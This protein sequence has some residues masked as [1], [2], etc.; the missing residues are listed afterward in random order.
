MPY[1]TPLTDAEA[2]DALRRL[3]EWT[4]DGDWIARTVELPTFRDAI[5]L[6]T[7][8]ADAAEQANHHPNI[9]IRWRR[10]S[11]RLTTHSAKALT[12]RDVDLAAR[13]DELAARGLGIE[14]P[15]R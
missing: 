12:R 4:R 9:D 13:I 5:A 14:S 2:D 3:P 8:V 7:A 6:V 11:F 15:R 10:V 1:A